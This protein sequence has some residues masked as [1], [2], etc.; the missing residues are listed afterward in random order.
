MIGTMKINETEL[1]RPGMGMIAR[2]S[3]QRPKELQQNGPKEVDSFRDD[4]AP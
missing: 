1:Q 2:E 3:R 4:Q